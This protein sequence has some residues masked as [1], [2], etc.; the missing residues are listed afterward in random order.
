VQVV[1]LD[2]PKQVRRIVVTVHADPRDAHGMGERLD[3]RAVEV[4]EADHGRDAQ[5]LG[6]QR[7][8]ERRALVGEG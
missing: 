1:D 3:P 2:L 8:V 4:A 6:H 7:R 5:L